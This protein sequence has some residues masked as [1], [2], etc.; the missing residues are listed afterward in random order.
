MSDSCRVHVGSVAAAAGCRAVAY[1]PDVKHAG[2]D[3]ML[4]TGTDI[5]VP[6]PEAIKKRLKLMAAEMSHLRKL[7]DAVEPMVRDLR[8]QPDAGDALTPTAEGTIRG[9]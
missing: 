2:D 1:S 3:T 7:L 8:L 4:L 9:I 5:H 6:R